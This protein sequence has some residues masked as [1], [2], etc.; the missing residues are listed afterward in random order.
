[1]EQRWV[2]TWVVSRRE[3]ARSTSYD[4]LLSPD[5]R[6]RAAT[7]RRSA[8]FVAGAVLLR[9][10][11]ARRTGI[12]PEDVRVR[13]CCPRCGGPHG[14]PELPGLGLTASVSH[15]G[16][17][18]AV[19]L[20]DTGWVGIDVERLREVPRSLAARVLSDH[21]QGLVT[22]EPAFFAIWTIKEALVKASGRGLAGISEHLVESLD[23]VWTL[24]PHG[25]VSTLP[26]P[27]GFAAAV[28]HPAGVH[29]Q[30]A[31]EAPPP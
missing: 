14:R 19:A 8:P 18:V 13:R 11:A 4:G 22:D 7:G 31:T 10:A 29:W 5:E 12:A 3:L 25:Q 9:L 15:S 28:A 1:M 24:D 16:D 20:T 17:L 30:H 27:L 6:A 23:P 26:V 2:D 21:E